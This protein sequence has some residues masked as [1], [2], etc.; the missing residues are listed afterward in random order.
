MSHVLGLN[1]GRLSLVVA[2]AASLL[3]TSTAWA[4]ESPAPGDASAAATDAKA[5]EE[6]A[7]NP[8]VVQEDPGFTV[9]Q[10]TYAVNNIMLFFAAVFV[11]FM[12]AGFAMLEVG[13]NEAKNVVNILCKNL[14]DLCVGILLFFVV[15][16][17]V[18]SGAAAAVSALF[19]G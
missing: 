5:P 9:G 8:K 10:V 6:A 16:G 3:F 18:I 14:M 15:P 19:A 13:F 12:Q 7:K 11:L 17:P 4:D 1:V 2:I